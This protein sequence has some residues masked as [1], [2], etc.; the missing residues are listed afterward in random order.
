MTL[1]ETHVFSD[2]VVN[3]ARLGFNRIRINFTPTPA[4]NPSTFNISGGVSTPIGLP[5][6]VVNGA[7]PLNFGGPLNEPQGRGDTTAVLSD[8]ISWLHGNHSFK[9]GGE[10]R[11]FLNANFTNDTGR[12]TFTDM[13]SFLAGNA[14]AFQVSPGTK[15]SRIATTAVGLFAVDSYKVLPYFTL[16][17]GLRYD[18]N[19]TPTE[20]LDRFVVFDPTT[21]SLVR[22]GHGIGEV[23]NQNAMNFEPRV[24]FSWDLFHDGKTI[25][26]SAYGYNVDQP[27]TN[28][29]TGLAG[30]PPFANPVSF[31]ASSATP[32]V[33][34]TTAFSFVSGAG[35]LTPATINHD[36]KNSYVQE[37]NLNI[38]QQVTSSTGIMV[39]YF[40]SKGTHLRVLRNANQKLT[41]NGVRPFA[42]LVSSTSVPCPIAPATKCPTLN[43]IN[44][45]DSDSSSNYNALWATATQRISHGLQFN[46]SYTWSKSLDFNSLTSQGAV[47]LED[48]TNPRLDY[49]PSDYDARHR[50]VISGIY[51]LPFHGNRVVEGWQVSPIVTLQS[52]S[53]VN[54]VMSSTALTGTATVRPDLLAPVGVF[55]HIITDPTTGQIGNIQWFTTTASNAVCTLAAVIPAGCVIAVPTTGPGLATTRFGNMRRNALPG[56]DFK[57]LDFS[58]T[59]NTKITERVTAELRAE[60]FDLFNHPNFSPPISGANAVAS[61]G[62][63]FGV[64]TSTRFPTGDSG[65]ARQIQ[66]AVKFKF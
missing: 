62:Q 50:L 25:L 15:P 7:V 4:L 27:V 52:G 63:L 34:I 22:V 3:E 11:R 8:S 66:F 51:D 47:N 61:P 46:A 44:E 30:N 35:S 49:G 65:S 21:G 39:G 55:N 9:F 58:V 23:Y 59:K 48:S 38:Q 24:G 19:G 36:F 16:E 41:L 43:N 64:I 28:A 18:W 42:T 37:W 5:N 57:N 14:N 12:F 56:P 1:N 29:V 10:F 20:A 54:V 13:P 17:L 60:F 31:S 6:I 45:V 2:H 33:P 53:P 32:T 26:R 40:G